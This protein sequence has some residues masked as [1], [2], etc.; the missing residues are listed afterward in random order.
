MSDT[1]TK[2]KYKATFILDTRG[3][4][5]PVDTL[6][7]KLKTTLQSIDCEVENVE[8]AGQKDFA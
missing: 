8:N 3:Y 7:E 1:V 5:E 6:I 2:N 4:E